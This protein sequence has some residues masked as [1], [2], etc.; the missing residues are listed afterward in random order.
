MITQRDWKVVEFVDKIP[1]YSDTIQKIILI[2]LCP[3]FLHDEAVI[4]SNHN[5]LTSDFP[6]K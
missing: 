4:V 3:N 2:L 5:L 6:F 1:C